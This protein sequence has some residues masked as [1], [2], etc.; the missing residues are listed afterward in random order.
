MIHNRLYA[1][2][3]KYDGEVLR[4]TEE[5][6]REAMF[7]PPHE[8]RASMLKRNRAGIE[9][10]EYIWK[11]KHGVEVPGPHPRNPY[12]PG[13]GVGSMLI[14]EGEQTCLL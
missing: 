4:A 2:A 3:V 12:R 5:E 9:L 7:R 10:A 14:K 6:L 13:E 1:L 8:T 11:R